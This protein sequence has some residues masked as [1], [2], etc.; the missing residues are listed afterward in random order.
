MS[1]LQGVSLETF[2]G[3]VPLFG[4]L[5]PDLRR[6]VVAYLKRREFPPNSTIV[7]EGGAGDAMFIIESGR[8]EVRKKDE[9][10]GISFELAQLGEGDFFGEMS[11]LNNKPRSASVIA[12]EPTS[13][14]VLEQFD[15]TDLLLNFP[16]IGLAL[17]QALAE[18]LEE[19]NEHVGYE[20]INL[21]KL[22]VDP[23]VAAML[24]VPL[25]KQ[26]KVIPISFANNS[27]TL[28]MSN[29][30]NI[31]ALD[32]IRRQIKGVVIET[33]IAPEAEILNFIDNV[34]PKLSESAEATGGE[35]ATAPAKPAEISNSLL[36]DL[37]FADTQ[38][39]MTNV[40][41]LAESADDA[42]IIRLAN[43]IL[44]MAIQK[45]ASDIHLEP[46]E[47]ELLLRL[48]IDGALSV[49]QVL[50]KKV[51]LPLISRMKI[52][53]NLDIAERR[54]PQDG[55]ISV[56]QDNK[57][58]DFRV[59][60]VPTRYGEKICMRILDKSNAVLGLDRLFPFEDVLAKVRDM[61]HQPY[62]IIFVTGP[63]GS[64]KT[65]TLYSALSELNTPDVNISTAEDPVEYD[66]E[67]INQIQVIK[68]IGLDFAR[69]LRAFLRQDPD[70]I[71]VGETRDR[72]TAKTAVEAA[73]TGHL[74]LT[75]LHTNDAPSSFLRLGEMGVEPFLVSSSTV[76]LVAQRLARRLCQK[77]K[78]AYTPEAE[79][80][81]YMGLDPQQSWT[82]YKAAG[83]EAC[84]G[85]GYKGRVGIYE[86]LRMTEPVRRLVAQGAETGEIKR[87]AIAEGMQTLKDY[88][89]RLM[90]EGLTSVEQVLEVVAVAD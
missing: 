64:G 67:G 10:T 20:F 51:Q 3:R 37:E 88:A 63:T 90:K 38:T 15:F 13:V 1:T 72:E 89:V 40:K 59:S 39:E 47:K 66:L 32:D 28:A 74:V 49:E 24:P 46:R 61:I 73:L 26:H 70:I 52:V 30:N 54:L 16:M 22:K 56:K 33:V 21:S 57:P 7:E 14:Y 29:P 11:L 23:R 5:D 53:A 36:K 55:R 18:R 35:G 44:S 77:C 17:S 2:L 82:F 19:V 58:I 84:N 79:T 76:G 69:V 45:G 65:T 34:L 78:E 62:G 80:V 48:R 27:L 87:V 83:C 31:L 81:K 12:L 71:L 4:N 68:E 25:M 60:T 8:V 6:K 50:P 43:T 9:M 75:T 42:P 86:V 85:S 41:D